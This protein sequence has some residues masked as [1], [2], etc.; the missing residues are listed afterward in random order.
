MTVTV[1]RFRPGA[2]CYVSVYRVE[3]EVVRDMTIMELLHFISENMDPTLGYFQHS[4]CCHGICRRCALRANGKTVLACT[5]PV[6]WTR[7][8]H[9][10]PAGDREPV[11]DLV[12]R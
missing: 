2:E 3:D 12:V 11:R 5:T 4:A 6:D 8:L 10:A 9:L 1:D 7:T